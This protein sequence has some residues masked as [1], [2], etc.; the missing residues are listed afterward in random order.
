[1]SRISW[2][3]LTTAVSLSCLL[4]APPVRA[5]IDA[6]GRWL[7]H[8]YTEFGDGFGVEDWQQTGSSLESG[9]GDCMWTGTIDVSSGNFSQSHPPLWSPPGICTS[10]YGT[11]ANMGKVSTRSGTVDMTTR[12]FSGSGTTCVSMPVQ[13]FCAPF[14]DRK[15]VV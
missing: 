4:G 12:T 6:S 13:C 1:M 15:S 14:G 5:D 9:S 8:T 11:C 7:I 2:I 10:V 3:V